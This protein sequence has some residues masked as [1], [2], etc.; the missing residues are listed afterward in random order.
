MSL[1]SMTAFASS[2]IELDFG[3]LSIELKSYNS[4]YLD[5]YC[6]LPTLLNTYEG[7]VRN[8]IA[9][10]FKRGKIE[11]NVRFKANLGGQ[12]NINNLQL[13]AFSSL[14]TE[15]N[16]KDIK[17]HYNLNDLERLGVFDNDVNIAKQLDAPFNKLLDEVII[18]CRNE[19]YAEGARL[20][21]AMQNSLA[22]I[23]KAITTIEGLSPQAEES[24]KQQLSS[25][26]NEVLGN[27]IEEGRL[28]EEI[29]SYIVRTNINEE[30]VRL[31]SHSHNVANI[32][33][34]NEPVGRLLDFMAQEIQREANTISAKTSLLAIQRAALSIKEAVDSLREQGRNIE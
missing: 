13:D 27:A 8:R 6:T 32:L 10:F 15:L 22:T 25:K 33:Q 7:V 23:N 28:L 31:Q 20:L 12:L 19:R 3:S 18:H 34:A 2:A 11:L 29:A 14:L 30:L 5:I 9:S 21:G 24:A 26:F 4:K 17:P 1:Q 16:N